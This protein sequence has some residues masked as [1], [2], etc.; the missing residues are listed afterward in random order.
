MVK[1]ID[2][3]E[4]HIEQVKPEL[5]Q[6]ARPLL[7]RLF[8]ILESFEH[9]QLSTLAQLNSAFESET[10]FVAFRTKLTNQSGHLVKF[11]TKLVP[12]DMS[13]ETF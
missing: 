7:E 12:G 11:L 9:L 4:E 2:F 6:L 10:E 8:A 3:N 13:G 5:K 1:A